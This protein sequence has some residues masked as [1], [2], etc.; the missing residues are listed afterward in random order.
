MVRE[1]RWWNGIGLE[2]DIMWMLITSKEMVMV[3][4]VSLARQVERLDSIAL[5]D[6]RQWESLCLW[7]EVE[8]EVEEDALHGVLYC[9]VHTASAVVLWELELER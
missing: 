5:R 7:C 2:W 3:F 6:R 1:V 9:T 4:R 8:V